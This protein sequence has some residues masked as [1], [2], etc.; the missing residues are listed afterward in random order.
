MTATA[1]APAHGWALVSIAYDGSV[2]DAWFPS[3]A[4]GAAPEGATAPA[5]LYIDLA[6]D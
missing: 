1:A 3:P 4:L 5:E 6:R 2:L